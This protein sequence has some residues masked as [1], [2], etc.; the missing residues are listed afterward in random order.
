M[1][2]KIVKDKWM[3]AEDIPDMDLFFAQVWLKAFVNDMSKTVGTNYREVLCIFKGTNI[4]FYYR[5][6]DSERF[7]RQVFNLIKKNPNFGEKINQQIKLHTDNLVAWA[8]ELRFKNLKK[9][10]NKELWQIWDR[11]NQLHTELYT[12]GWLPNVTDMFHGNFT[13]YLKSYLKNRGVSEDLVNEYLITLTNPTEKSIINQEREEFLRLATIIQKLKNIKKV[14]NLTPRQFIENLPAAEQI[15]LQ[16]HWAKWYHLKYNFIGP[17]VTRLEEYAREIQQL[18]LSGVKPYSLLRQEE[19]KRELLFRAK[20]KLL[21]K[22]KPDKKHRALFELWGQFMLTKFYRRNGQIRALVILNQLLK[23]TARRLRVSL[24]QV[25]LMLYSQVKQALLRNKV[26]RKK[27]KKQS[28]LAV[29]WA[30]KGREYLY[31]GSQAE[32]LI[33]S[34]STDNN[35]LVSELNGQCGNLGKATGMVRLIFRSRDISKMSKGD[36]LIS[37]ATDPDIVPAMK[38]AAAIVTDQGGVTAHAAIVSRELGIP[39]LIGTKIATKVF[40]D[41]DK[42]EVDATKGI[43]KKVK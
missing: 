26:N 19:E 30:V 41:G 13:N 2:K 3:L 20:Q 29:Y 25:R 22:I 10:S 12:W 16:W 4:K 24:L 40:K 8:E 18:L 35:K 11:H 21:A 27:L 33:K 6:K 38:L 37:I 43:I 42:V 1:T 5:Q 14:V 36:I 17:R 23:E 28:H 39:C 9:M 7:S 15:L 31:T 34:V 32:K